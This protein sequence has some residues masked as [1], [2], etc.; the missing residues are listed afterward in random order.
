MVLAFISKIVYMCFQV[1]N[2]ILVLSYIDHQFITLG[3][4]L[5]DSLDR[6]LKSNNREKC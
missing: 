2:G 4:V 5:L 1:Q 3:L 6:E